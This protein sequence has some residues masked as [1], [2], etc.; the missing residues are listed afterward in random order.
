MRK[1]PRPDG[2]PKLDATLRVRVPLSLIRRLDAVA[3]A[4]CPRSIIARRLLM[5]A[6]ESEGCK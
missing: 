1:P 2:R 4:H 5:R 3:E 6:L